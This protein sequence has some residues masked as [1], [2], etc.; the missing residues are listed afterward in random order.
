MCATEQIRTIGRIQSYGFLV[1][2]DE[3]SGAAVLASANAEHLLGRVLRDESSDLASILDHGSA[4]DPVRADF[5]GQAVDVIVHRGTTPSLVEFEPVIPE[6]DY[7]RTGVVSA[8]QRL[9]GASEEA[10]LWVAAAREI[11]NLTGFDRVMCYD[12]HADGHGQIVADEREP[13]MEPYF[14]L[15]FP[16]SDIPTQARALYIEKRSRVIADTEDPG[17]PVRSLL[18]G[19]EPID[20]GPTE[21]RAVSPHHLTFMRNMGQASTFSLSLVDNGRLMGMITCAHRS[22]HRLP[23]LLRRALEVLATEISTQIGYLRRISELQRRLDAQ[24]RRAAVIASLFD[25]SDPGE[26]LTT[27]APTVLDIV[28]ADG[29]V[30]RLGGAVHSI[31]RVPSERAVL[32][33]VEHPDFALRAVEDLPVTHPDAA[34]TVP[35]VAGLLVVPLGDDDVLVFVRREVAQTVEWL[36]DQR[37]DNRDDALSPRRSFSAWR[38]SV[39]GR[40]LPWGHHAQDAIDFGD[41]LRAALRA[42]AQA[43]LADLALQDPLTGL[44]NRRFLRALLDGMS[45][46]ESS[47]MTVIFFDVDDFKS[48]ND[49]HGHD[50]GDV[51]LRTI[52]DRLASVVRESDSVVRLGGDEFLIVCPATGIEQAEEVAARALSAIAEPIEVDRAGLIV[53]ASAGVVA[54]GDN[55]VTA[56]DAAMYRAKNAGGGRVSV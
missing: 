4:V 14:G 52:A 6:F 17:I 34:A 53:R 12:F 20:L 51:V 42:K 25:R 46:E 36:G 23:V 13:E 1:G 32:L 55:V 43:E 21:M 27:G 9:A 56:A 16:A 37:S 18:S 30:V 33:L 38:E 31:G 15:R 39:T 50:A 3:E 5:D 19:D 47:D 8:I 7:R 24:E 41:G 45:G 26:V 54:G 10:V 22:P 48:I 49:A 44:H 40:S 28:P 29:A 35:G 2:V 11:K